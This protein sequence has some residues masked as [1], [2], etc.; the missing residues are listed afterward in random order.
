[1]RRVFLEGRLSGW[2]MHSLYSELV[3][4]PPDGYKFVV[5]SQRRSLSSQDVIYSL[6][7]KLVKHYGTKVIY[8]YLRPFWYYTNYRLDSRSRPTNVDLTYA[9]QHV[10]FRKEPWVVDLEHAGALVAYGKTQAFKKTIEKSLRS[11]YCRKIL[12]WTEMGKKTLFSCFDCRGFEEKIEVVNLAVHPKKF[13]KKFDDNKVKLLFVG[14]ANRVNII[15]SFAIKGGN[16]ALKAFEILR[17]KYTNLEL[18]M[19]SYVPR[20]VKERCFR[21]KEVRIIDGIV[22]WEALDYEFRTADIFLFPGHSTPGMVI[23][24]AMSYE[25]PVIATNVW[26][27][28]ELVKERTTGFLIRESSKVRYYGEDFVPFWGEPAFMNAIQRADMGMVEDLVEKTSTL[29]EDGNFRRNMGRAARREIE[30][31]K[32]SVSARNDRLKRIFDKAIISG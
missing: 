4:F 30:K 14:T 27:N 16:E 29:I 31:G 10:V 24:D 23:L 22:P 7:R 11:D 21:Y 17:T 32:F 18:V 2:D 1:M 13:R 28:R 25:L 15:D 3:H 19:R 20:D 6:N 8:D 12:P 9:S 5:V 26:A